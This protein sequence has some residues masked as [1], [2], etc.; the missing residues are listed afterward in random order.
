ML[1]PTGSTGPVLFNPYSDNKVSCVNVLKNA[2]GKVLFANHEK[3]TITVA[4][5][6]QRVYEF[7]KSIFYKSYQMKT[8]TDYVAGEAAIMSEGLSK[9]QLCTL[10]YGI[11][12]FFNNEGLHADARKKIFSRLTP[13]PPTPV[14]SLSDRVSP[15][16]S[17]D[18]SRE[19]SSQS[20][21]TSTP[22]SSPEADLEPLMIFSPGSESQK[23]ASVPEKVLLSKETISKD[24]QLKKTCIKAAKI[25]AAVVAVG[26]LGAIA[27]AIII[28][29]L[30]P[31]YS[32][33]S[34]VRFDSKY[35]DGMNR[36]TVLFEARATYLRRSPFSECTIQINESWETTTSGSCFPEDLEIAKLTLN[37]RVV[38][39][40]GIGFWER[41]GPESLNLKIVPKLLVSSVTDRWFRDPLKISSGSVPNL[42]I[43]P[44]DLD[45]LETK[46]KPII[47][48][49]ERLDGSSPVV[50]L[51]K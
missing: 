17:E 20:V 15:M 11:D 22:V 7:V 38:K 24:V 28:P 18:S 36:E 41:E 50:F 10:Y 39:F 32:M 5:L 3:G 48:K 6:F 45:F 30:L 35:F 12:S 8:S 14:D 37:D 23:N 26:F 4:T 47:M 2:R 51:S 33:N 16:P 21:V 42:P 9:H 44:L 34:E 49:G 46:R 19:E 25:M 1:N 27:A 31:K 40:M 13:T 43:N 29:D